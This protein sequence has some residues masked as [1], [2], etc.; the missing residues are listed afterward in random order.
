MKSLMSREA[1]KTSKNENGIIKNVQTTQRTFTKIDCFLDHKTN[2]S[3]FKRIEI[4]SSVN[5]DCSGIKLEISNG[6][7]AGNSPNTWTHT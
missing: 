6:K 1:L 4:I 2:F 5:F 7:I 3:K